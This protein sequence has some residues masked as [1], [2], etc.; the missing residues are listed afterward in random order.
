MGSVNWSSKALGTIH[1]TIL[2]QC[3]T[4]I[5]CLTP[6]APMPTM[7]RG[8]TYYAFQRTMAKRFM[9]TVPSSRHD[10]IANIAPFA[11]RKAPRSPIQMRTK[12]KTPTLGNCSSMNF[13]PGST[14]F[15]RAEECLSRRRHAD[16]QLM[17]MQ[18][19]AINDER[20]EDLPRAIFA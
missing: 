12:K 10:I 19:R 5:A 13:L 8:G 15:R 6:Y 9:N 14:S 16:H 20:A 1:E 2:A 11:R 7:V 18:K 17:Q 3:S 4:R